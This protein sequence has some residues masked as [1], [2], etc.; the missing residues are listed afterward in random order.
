MWW[1]RWMSSTCD[2]WGVVEGEVADSGVVGAPADGV[3]GYA[4]GVCGGDVFE[5]FVEVAVGDE[6]VLRVVGSPVFGHGRAADGVEGDGVV[7]EFVDV[8]VGPLGQR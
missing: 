4:D 7:A 8:Q 3:W 1:V 5:P 6:A 2:G